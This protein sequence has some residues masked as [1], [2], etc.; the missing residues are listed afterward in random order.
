MNC[1]SPPDAGERVFFLYFARKAAHQ[2]AKVALHQG[3]DKTEDSLQDAWCCLNC[4]TAVSP[5]AYSSYL[6][7]LNDEQYLS[8]HASSQRR[9]I[10]SDRIVPSNKVR[11]QYCP[12]KSNVPSE[13][14]MLSFQHCRMQLVVIVLE[15]RVT[16]FGS[17]NKLWLLHKNRRTKSVHLLVGYRTG[18]S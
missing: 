16:R 13:T 4:P 3:L 2:V 18:L 11:L 9:S 12:T 10:C 14:I 8:Q 17:R 15:T 1:T 5:P 6:L 7:C